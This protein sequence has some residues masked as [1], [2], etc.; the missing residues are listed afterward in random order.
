MLLKRLFQNKFISTCF[1]RYMMNRNDRKN[2]RGRAKE[3]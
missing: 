2:P 3:N 1:S